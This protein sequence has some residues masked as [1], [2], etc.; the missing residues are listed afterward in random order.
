MSDRS[1]AIPPTGLEPTR[2]PLTAP[3]YVEV[4]CTDKERH[5]RLGV[6]FQILSD[7][8]AVHDYG[9]AVFTKSDGE[10]YLSRKLDA[11]EGHIVDTVSFSE[12][13][14]T[15]R[16]TCRRCKRDVRRTADNFLKILDALE[17]NDIN[18]LDL[19]HLQS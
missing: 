11:S 12:Q 16:L 17:T 7:D 9:K 6:Q 8:G 2:A 13:A 15:R 10:W 3:V 14:G 4:L 18:S 1:P 5:Q 19:S